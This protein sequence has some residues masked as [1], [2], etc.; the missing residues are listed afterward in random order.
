M[1]VV[2]ETLP[3]FNVR[4]YRFL[5]SLIKFGVILRWL[6]FCLLNSSSL[7]AILTYPHG[8][9]LISWMTVNWMWLHEDD[10]V[11]CSVSPTFGNWFIW[12]SRYREEVFLNKILKT[13]FPPLSATVSALMNS[14]HPWVILCGNGVNFT[15]KWGEPCHVILW[16]LAVTS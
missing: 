13:P 6:P 15:G 3:C 8:T 2:G 5:C 4:S 9:Q 10:W 14:E 1:I 7:Q 12:T 16:G 11:E